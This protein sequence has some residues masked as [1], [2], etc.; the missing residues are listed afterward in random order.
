MIVGISGRGKEEGFFN[1]EG[2]STPKKQLS[3]MGQTRRK[4]MGVANSL[5]E[6]VGLRWRMMAGGGRRTV[7]ARD[8][9]TMAA[10][11][12]GMRK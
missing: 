3:W 11:L 5:Q 4:S 9:L 1:G 6:E 10:G 8:K 7:E 12:T 2:E